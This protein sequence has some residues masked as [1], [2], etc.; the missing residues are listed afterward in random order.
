M[1][2]NLLYRLSIPSGVVEKVTEL[3]LLAR[4]IAFAPNLAKLFIVIEH[5]TLGQV[6]FLKK[7]NTIGAFSSPG[8]VNNGRGLAWHDSSLITEDEKHHFRGIYLEKGGQI[9]NLIGAR[10]KQQFRNVRR[11]DKDSHHRLNGFASHRKSNNVFYTSPEHHGIFVIHHNSQVELAIGRGVPGFCISSDP[12]LNE[13]NSP[14]GIAITNDN[15]MFVA[16][17]G[18]HVIREFSLKETI[19]VGRTIGTPETPGQKDGKWQGVIL[20]EPMAM[21]CDLNNVYFVDDG[22][23]K[24]KSCNINSLEIKTVHQTSNCIHYIAAGRPS[25]LYFTELKEHHGVE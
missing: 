14:T 16:D 17:K 19:T 1:P 24:L 5:P 10:G 8:S 25:E 9:K 22:G 7:D 12:L 11:H 23:H 6:G 21:T 15:R 13:F 2:K 18:N 20:N 3:P 4:G